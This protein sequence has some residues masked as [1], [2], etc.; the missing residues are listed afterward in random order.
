MTRPITLLLL[1]LATPA[2]GFEPQNLAGHP[3]TVQMN[4]AIEGNARVPANPLVEDSKV[5][6]MP[7]VADVQLQYEERSVYPNGA[8]EGAAPVVQRHFEKA[9][10]ENRVNRSRQ[11]IT[12]RP[13]AVSMIAHRRT[14]PETTHVPAV[15]LLRGELEL[16]EMPI[17]S[18]DLDL[19]IDRHLKPGGSKMAVD[20]ATAAAVFNLSSIDR[21]DLQI[22][23]TESTDG[24]TK[25]ELTGDLTGHVDGV[26]TSI[27]VVGKLTA[28]DAAGCITW[29]AIA[30][31]ETRNAGVAEPGYDAKLTIRC[32]RTPTD[33]PRRLAAKVSPP[34]LQPPAAKDLLVQFNSDHLGISAMAD[35]RWRVMRDVPGEVMLRMVDADQSIAQCRIV[36]LPAL[37]PDASFAISDLKNDVRKQLGDQFGTFTEESSGTTAMGLASHRVGAAGSVSGVPIAWT[38]MHLA[39]PSGRRVAVTWTMAADRVEQLAGT[40]VQ[41]VQTM[42]LGESNRPADE[43]AK[44]VPADATKNPASRLESWTSASQEVAEIASA[45]DKSPTR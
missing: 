31:H 18:V 33:Q 26:G 20:N 44:F 17:A 36:P 23:C 12:L 38:V 4:V 7:I 42:T 40:D 3:V 2:A 30:I 14:L 21:N 43:L 9:V 25:Y 34:I 27:R 6:T 1:L 29:A 11:T 13:E 37:A 16:V 22:R 35:R 24:K 41:M 19:L 32:T 45:S 39:D 15:A 28:T 8:A 10:S 5:A